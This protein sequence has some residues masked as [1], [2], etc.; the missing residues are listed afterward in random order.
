MPSRTDNME[1]EVKFA[2]SPSYALP[3]LRGIVG[4]TERLP[5]QLLSTAYHDTPDLRLWR[6]G[7]TLRFRSGEEPGRGKWTLKLPEEKADQT[8]DRTEL[9][10]EGEE[11]TVPAETLSLVRGIVR[12]ATLGPVVHLASTRRRLLLLDRR[13]GVL[14]EIDDDV[15]TVA[16][17][18]RDGFRFRQIEF[19]FTG[20]P[21]PAVVDAVLKKIRRAGARLDHEQKFAKSLGL[22]DGASTLV[23]EKA[24]KKKKGKQRPEVSIGAVVQQSIE[25]A[26]DRILDHDYRLRL[27]PSDPPTEAVHQARVA[28]RRLRSDLKTFSLLLDPIWLAHTTTELKWLGTVLGRVRD[29]DVLG[30]RL[31]GSGAGSGSDEPLEAQGRQDLCAMVAEERR[32]YVAE[33]A[34]VVDGPRYFSLLER[35]YAAAHGPPFYVQRKARSTGGQPLRIESPARKALPPLVEI[36][37]RALRR[38]KRKAGRH[39]SDRQ[40]HRIRIGAKQL[41]YAAEAAGPVMGKPARR[42]ARRAE[43]VQTVLGDH[44]DA[45]AAAEWLRGAALHGT[46]AASFAAGLLTATQQR[47]QRSLRRQWEGPWRALDAKTTRQWLG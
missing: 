5:K 28:C 30:H 39:P 24:G 18:A 45:V 46:G 31:A 35:L 33:L 38:R 17:G 20:E 14:G 15:V 9:S 32:Q 1:R 44:H 42:M 6:R 7:L 22:R 19:E 27:A 34:E 29:A 37:W 8:L 3:D 13:G 21:D 2:A 36:Q 26:L 4:A 25:G 47:R 10:W 40:L 11:D 16:G 23:K 12:R 41:R 43:T